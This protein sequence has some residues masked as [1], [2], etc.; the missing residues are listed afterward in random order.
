LD[1]TFL[2][3]RVIVRF[4]VLDPIRD[5]LHSMPKL[6]QIAA[7]NMQDHITVMEVSAPADEA[8]RRALDSRSLAANSSSTSMIKVCQTK[9]L[10]YR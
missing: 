9:H 5:A 2:G 4:G 8:E 6:A 3:L 7:R 1:Q 10:I